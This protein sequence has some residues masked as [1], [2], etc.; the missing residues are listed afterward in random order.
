MKRYEAGGSWHEEM[1]KGDD[2][3]WIYY[4][5]DTMGW[6]GDHVL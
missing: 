6:N 4:G 1:G 3:T 2:D 5:L